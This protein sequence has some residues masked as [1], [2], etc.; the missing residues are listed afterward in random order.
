MVGARVIVRR[1]IWVHKRRERQL[2]NVGVVISIK[3]VAPLL[4]SPLLRCV[5]WPSLDL[6]GRIAQIEHMAVPGLGWLW[7]LGGAFDFNGHGAL[8]IINPCLNTMFA[9]SSA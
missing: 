6:F 4:E 2:P 7:P 5:G 3:F 9:T 8:G 1:G